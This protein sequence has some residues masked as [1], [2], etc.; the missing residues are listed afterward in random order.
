MKEIKKELMDDATF[1]NLVARYKRE[2][3]GAIAE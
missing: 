2:T 3:D 1:R